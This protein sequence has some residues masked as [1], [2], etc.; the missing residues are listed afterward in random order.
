LLFVLSLA[1]VGWNESRHLGDRVLFEEMRES[2]RSGD[3]TRMVG[4]LDSTDRLSDGKFLRP[5]PWLRLQRVI[6]VYQ[7]PAQLAVV[8]SPVAYAGYRWMPLETTNYS[9]THAS[10]AKLEGNAIIDELKDFQP[11]DPGVWLHDSQAAIRPGT[12]WIYPERRSLYDPRP[13]DVRVSFRAILPGNYSVLASPEDGRVEHYI[14][15]QGDR[16]LLATRGNIDEATMLQTVLRRPGRLS[17][18]LRW[19]GLTAA[20]VGL[21]IIFLPLLPLPA[22][23][24]RRIVAD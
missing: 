23:R 10:F 18:A 13:G 14:S 16:I 21:L 2:L 6:Q 3:L 9:V 20:G 15:R 24:L 11:L 4:R 7:R 17:R 22:V 12:H 5:G 1:A 8:T 19:S